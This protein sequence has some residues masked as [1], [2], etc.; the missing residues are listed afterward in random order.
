MHLLLVDQF[1]LELLVEMLILHNTPHFKGQPIGRTVLISL[2]M[3]LVLQPLRDVP[4]GCEAVFVVDE[5]HFDERD[6]H[7]KVILL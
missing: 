2:V 7:G 5:G 4:L 6:R 3:L 1:L